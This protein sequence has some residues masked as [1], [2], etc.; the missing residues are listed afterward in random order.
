MRLRHKLLTPHAHIPLRRL[1]QPELALPHH[2][3]KRNIQLRVRDMDAQTG[4]RAARETRQVPRQQLLAVW[5]ERRRAG[6]GVGEP[7][8][9]VEGVG[10]G[11]DGFRVRHVVCGHG[12]GDARGDGVGFV[13]EG[14]GGGAGETQGDAVVEADCYWC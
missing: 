8:R 1:V 4:A 13:L 5:A 11:E 9:R 7:A 6:D 2:R 14:G 3:R 12:E 10:G